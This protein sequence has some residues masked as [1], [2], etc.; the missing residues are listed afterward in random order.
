MSI[1]IEPIAPDGSIRMHPIGKARSP[2]RSQQTGGFQEVES[3]IDLLPEFADYLL[4]LEP[5]SHLIVVYW[6][7][8]QT[9]PKATTRP[10]G[11]PLVPEV[12]MFACR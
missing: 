4:G 7:H 10:Q 1:V 5:Y 11:N 8:E 6:M 9:A 12:G 2:I 3:R